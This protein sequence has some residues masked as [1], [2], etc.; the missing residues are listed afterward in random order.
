MYLLDTLKSR[1]FTWPE[2]WWRPETYGGVC[3]FLGI[4]D[5]AFDAHATLTILEDREEEE[6]LKAFAVEMSPLVEAQFAAAEKKFGRRFSEEDMRS[7]LV[8]LEEEIRATSSG[9]RSA[10]CGE[11]SNSSGNNPGGE[12]ELSKQETRVEDT[13]ET[14]AKAKD[15]KGTKK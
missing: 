1:G 7:F 12:D 10:E 9:Q 5:K 4:A 15:S 14:K 3:S 11:S 13:K 2:L 8:M 6:R